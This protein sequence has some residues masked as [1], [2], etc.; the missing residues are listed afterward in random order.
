M[1]KEHYRVTVAEW[2]LDCLV[3]SAKLEADARSWKRCLLRITCAC[4]NCELCKMYLCITKV[5]KFG[6]FSSKNLKLLTCHFQRVS[7]E[8]CLTGFKKTDPKFELLNKVL[9]T[10]LTEVSQ[11]SLE[12]LR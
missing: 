10:P 2:K 5:C 7:V 3:S 4:D 11:I 8:S 9:L 12:W 6:I 1:S